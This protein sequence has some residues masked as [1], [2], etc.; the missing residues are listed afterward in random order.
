MS[1]ETEPTL[2]DTDLIRRSFLRMA[3]AAEGV[4]LR[5]DQ[6]NRVFAAVC[7]GDRE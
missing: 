2:S 3:L 6:I 1:K 7:G 4:H 5:E